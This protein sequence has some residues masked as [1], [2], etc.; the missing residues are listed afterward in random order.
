[1]PHAIE[2]GQVTLEGSLLIGSFSREEELTGLVVHNFFDPQLRTGAAVYLLKQVLHDW[3]DEFCAKILSQ[4]RAAVGPKT[5]LVL[6]DSIMPFAC[7]D[8]SANSKSGIPGAV[9]HE[10]PT[11]LL[12]NFGAVN[13]MGYNADIDVR[14]LRPLFN[15]VDSLNQILDV[16]PL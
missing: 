11:P 8:P 9:P 10:A 1:M 14:T 3:S 7:H 15:I 16:P 5:K 13:E 4:L 2:S 12:A 6:M